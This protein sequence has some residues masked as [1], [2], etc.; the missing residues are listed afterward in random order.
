METKA[1]QT[2]GDYNDHPDALDKRFA[3]FGLRPL[4]DADV[5][6]LGMAAMVMPDGSP[7]AAAP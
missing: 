7:G 3:R 5:W 6:A 4:S 1:A 2:V